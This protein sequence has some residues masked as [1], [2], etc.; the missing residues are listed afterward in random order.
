[1]RPVFEIDGKDFSWLIEEAGIKWSRNDLDS[2]KS[3][4]TL[5]GA[6]QRS[7]IGI[8]RKLSVTCLRMTTE[9]LMTLNAA[10][11]P[12]FIQVK[13]LDAIDGV[14]TRTFYGSAVEAATLVY[15]DGETHWSSTA[16]DLIER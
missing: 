16:F 4:R 6:M 9:Q 12:A 7:R 3:G 13:Y 8:K 5:D 10:L 2:D 1:M 15:I 14:T 11:L